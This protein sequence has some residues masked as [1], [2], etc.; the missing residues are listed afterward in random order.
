MGRRRSSV[1]MIAV[2]VGLWVGC[3]LYP[4][5]PVSSASSEECCWEKASKPE[6]LPGWAYELPGSLGGVVA[7][8]CSPLSRPARSVELAIDRAYDNLARSHHVRVEAWQA[9][10][11]EE[12]FVFPMQYSNEFLEEGAVER[13]QSRAVVLD[14]FVV[15]GREGS[16]TVRTYVLV[17]SSGTTVPRKS[18]KF[19]RFRSSGPPKWFEE[20]PEES[21]YLFG[22]GSCGFYPDVSDSWAAVE[23]QA[24]LDLA[25]K[26][27]TKSHVS[28]VDELRRGGGRTHR[29]REQKVEAD[30]RGAIVVRRHYD[31]KKRMFYALVRMP[32][33]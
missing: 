6:G 12:R 9:E 2:A 30:L 32:E 13:C 31:P 25:G 19:H 14:T 21:G 28:I 27:L 26:V 8:G 18:R 7:V 10:V 23:K 5:S 29:L 3:A 16:R 33:R 15:K 1:P 24:R 20:P 4:H 11:V 22:V 17:G